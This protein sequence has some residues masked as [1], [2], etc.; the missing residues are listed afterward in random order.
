MKVRR[1]RRVTRFVSEFV[2]IVGGVLAALSVDSCRQY[3]TD[4]GDE[5][6]YLEQVAADSRENLRL[7]AEATALEQKHLD[8]ALNL[9]EAA[10]QESPPSAD[11]VGAWLGRRDGSWW[12]S[13]PRLRDGTV[14]AL[15][16][17][18]DFAQ[19]L[20]ELLGALQRVIDLIHHALG[21]AIDVVTQLRFESSREKARGIDRLQ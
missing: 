8:V 9:W 20:D 3:Q 1:M 18:G 5:D 6:Y 16:Q 15:V 11:S 19:L 14:T 21:P 4:R 2:V 12:Y 7:I 17:T 13:D 10:Q